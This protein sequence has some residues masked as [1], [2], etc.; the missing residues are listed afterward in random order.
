MPLGFLSKM[1]INTKKEPKPQLEQSCHRFLPSKL[2]ILKKGLKWLFVT[3]GELLKSRFFSKR[4]KRWSIAPFIVGWFH[5]ISP[6][7]LRASPTIFGLLWASLQDYLPTHWLLG[8]YHHWVSSVCSLSFTTHLMT[9]KS[10]FVCSC[11]LPLP[12]CPNG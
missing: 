8:H 11:Y 3:I 7:Y 5:G 1:G 4:G 10:L 2:Y 12:S 9:K 6:F